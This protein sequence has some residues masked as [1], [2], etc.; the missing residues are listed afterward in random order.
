[1]LRSL[2]TIRAREMIFFKLKLIYELYGTG[3]ISRYLAPIVFLENGYEHFALLSVKI[4]LEN[5]L[6]M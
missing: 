4:D 5:M 6:Y 3:H 1:M 2:V